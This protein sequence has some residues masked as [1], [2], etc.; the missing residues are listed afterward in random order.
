MALNPYLHFK[1]NC[2]EAFDYYR[3]VFGGEFL[4]LS[5]FAE[6]PPEMEITDAERNQIMH[7]SLPVGANVLMGSDMPACL[8]AAPE[9]GNNFS[10]SVQAQNREHADKLHADLAN[11]GRVQMA[12]QDMFWGDYFGSCTDRFGINWMVVFSVA[13]E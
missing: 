9:A 10:I 7:V 3:L 11:G 6:G 8:G 4:M 5:T 1:G 2:R 12:M 13:A